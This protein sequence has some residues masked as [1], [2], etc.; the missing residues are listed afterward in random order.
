M[1]NE[2]YV[3]IHYRK[4]ILDKRVEY[5]VVVPH[6]Q[7]AVFNTWSY[8]LWFYL[9]SMFKNKKGIILLPF[10]NNWDEKSK[11]IKRY[12]AGSSAKECAKRICVFIDKHNSTHKF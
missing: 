10:A 7:I 11:I 3:E 9:G 5:S 8:W 4:N 12:V 1:A 6:N 2:R